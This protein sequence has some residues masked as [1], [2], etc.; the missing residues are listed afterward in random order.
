MRVKALSFL[1]LM[2]AACAPTP[3]PAVTPVFTATQTERPPTATSTPNPTATAT[4]TPSP[5][6]I[7]CYLTESVCIEDGHFLLERPISDEFVNTIHPGYRY[8][9]TIDGT[10]EPHHGVEFVNASGTPVLAAADGRVIFA[11]NDKAG[12]YSYWADFYGNLVVIEHDLPELGEPLYTLYAHLSV[13]GVAEGDL[14]E[15]GQQIGEVGWTGRAIG[16]HLHFEVRRGGLAYG[17]TRNPELWLKPTDSEN[18]AIAVQLINQRGEVRQVAVNV[19][20]VQ[21][22][23]SALKW[24][25]SLPAYAPETE[26]VGIDDAWQE[27]HAIGD[28]PAGS[29]RLSFIYAGGYWEQY[30]DVYPLQVTVVKFLIAE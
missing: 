17:D 16:S 13:I 14:V 10:R 28:L 12:I 15:A 11:E 7:P 4:F 18:G 26:P 5:T 6:P 30:V 27:S 24:V 25:A 20:Q 9:S 23:Q 2:L 1:L 19:D 8:G 22:G 3:T 21:D 29:Y